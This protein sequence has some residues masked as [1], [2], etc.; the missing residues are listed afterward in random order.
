[1]RLGR[2][3]Q[4]SPKVEAVLSDEPRVV[5]DASQLPGIFSAPQWL[6]D[7]G[8]LAWFLVGVGILL[9]GLVWIF[10]AISSIAIP[11]IVGGIV[12]SVAGP[13]VDAMERRRIPR[14]AGAAV[15]VLALV[16]IAIGV[17]LLVLAGVV[18]QA[19]Q[20]KAAANDA[21]AKVQG[22]FDDAD[23]NSTDA[24]QSVASAV[25]SAGHTLLHGVADGI[26][27]LTSIA[28]G[29]S[30][31]LFSTFFILKDGP[32]IR[33]FVDGHLG[34]PEAVA[35]AITGRTISSMRAYFFGLTIVAV[36]NG[37]VVGLGAWAL[38]VPLAGTIAIV[39]ALL[40]YIP[41][42]GAFVAGAFA[43][44]LALASEGTT[45][46]LIML[47]IVILANGLLQNIVQ[48]IAF[49][50]TLDLN[51]LAVLIVTISAGAL[52]GMI[53]MIIA[54]PLL[55]AAVKVTGDLRRAR[56]AALPAEPPEPLAPEP[57]IAA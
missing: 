18:D 9:V 31:T 46:A 51:P 28:I 32:K 6:R 49:G 43:V 56:L 30:F 11:V 55:S 23:A 36:F 15:V 3:F 24:T 48:P 39:T 37:A 26:K 12:A 8:F 34:V 38:G 25:P 35:T 45:T 54:A 16:A 42:I 20:I 44:V 57:E 40:A 1:V 10:D 53:G 13:I 41:F 33:R 47:V 5:I 2:F 22:W 4:R 19:D 50:A 27:G 29:L 14:A 7:L 52:V 21:L 17:V